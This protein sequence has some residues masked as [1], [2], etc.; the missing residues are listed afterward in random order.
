M[1]IEISSLRFKDYSKNL[2]K[3]KKYQ[4][5]RQKTRQYKDILVVSFSR[6]EAQLFHEKVR[7]EARMYCSGR[8]TLFWKQYKQQEITQDFEYNVET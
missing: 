2:S 8:M 3:S 6:G 1:S 4:K 7:T 5:S